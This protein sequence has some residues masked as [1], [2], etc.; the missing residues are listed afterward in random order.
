VRRDPECPVCGSSPSI[1]KPIDYDAFCGLSREPSSTAIPT[2][3]VHDLK[4][5]ITDRDLVVLDVR[6]QFEYEIARIQ[7]AQLIPLGELADRVGEVSREKSIVVMC[8]TGA[9]SASAATFLRQQG[10]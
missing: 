8:K 4:E 1:T 9:R 2:M 3:S 7:S 6:E 5:R 10:F